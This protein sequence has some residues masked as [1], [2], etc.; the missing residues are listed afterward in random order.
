QRLR[1]YRHSAHHH[2]T[3]AGQQSVQMQHES[4]F[5]R[6]VGPEERYRLSW[7]QF[8]V[9]AVQ[10]LRSVVV[11]KAEITDLNQRRHTKCAAARTPRIPAHTITANAASAH[12]KLL[13]PS[14]R[15]PP[16]KPRP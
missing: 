9:H 7:V 5:S 12:R 14:G 6:A 2:L 3:F 4:R 16:H 13:S 11:T 10:R 15:T 1:L 8:K